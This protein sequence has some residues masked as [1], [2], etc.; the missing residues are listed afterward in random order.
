V[1]FAVPGVTVWDGLKVG[2][3]KLKNGTKLRLGMEF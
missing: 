1:P 2:W 3:Y